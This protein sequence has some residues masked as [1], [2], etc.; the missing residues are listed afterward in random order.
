MKK[1]RR[2]ILIILVMIMIGCMSL[3]IVSC[4]MTIREI[5]NEHSVNNSKLIASLVEDSIENTMTEPISVALT[6]SEDVTLKDLFTPGN[7]EN[8]EVVGR[9]IRYLDSI[10]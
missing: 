3:S 5:S 1:K 6:M 4:I 8:N 7:Y 9:V 10:K 2:I